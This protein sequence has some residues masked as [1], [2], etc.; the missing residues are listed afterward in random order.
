MSVKELSGAINALDI[1]GLTV[2]VGAVS[3]WEN[4][5]ASP[6]PVTQLAIASALGVL[7]ST[8]FSLDGE[9]LK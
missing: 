7:W 9:T 4:G 5:V 1:R 2:T 3:H 6:R 8:L